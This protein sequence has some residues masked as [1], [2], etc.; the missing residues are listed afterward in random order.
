MG[1]KKYTPEARLK[2]LAGH[3]KNPNAST[4]EKLTA[5]LDPE[6]VFY[7]QPLNKKEAAAMPTIAAKRHRKHKE[8]VSKKR[9]TGYKAGGKVEVK[10]CKTCRGMGAATRGGKFGR[11]G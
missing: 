10:N 1:I 3:L 11:N 2:E 6:E 4:S 9:A 8:R 7:T 5:M